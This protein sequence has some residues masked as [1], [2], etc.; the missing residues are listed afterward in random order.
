M[1]GIG[2][3]DLSLHR[4]GD[5]AAPSGYP[6]LVSVGL[7]FRGP[8]AVWGSAAGRDAT[9]ARTTT[10][11]GASFP[12]TRLD[13][14]IEVA[15]TAY[16]NG[17]EPTTVTVVADLPLALPHIDR[18]PDGRWLV[19]GSRCRW[20]PEGPENNALLY[21]ADGRLLREGCLGDGLSHVRV[22]P[23]NTIWTGYFDE[24][25]YGNFG[26]G[27][28]SGPQ[29]LGAGGIVTWDEDFRKVWELNEDEFLVDDCYTLNV[30]DGVAWACPYANFPVVRMAAGS[31]EVFATE[32]ITGPYAV[33]AQG[34]R[35][36]MLGTYG[37]PTLVV[38]GRLGEGLLHEEGRRRLRA[39]DLP[40]ERRFHVYASGPVVHFFVGSTWSTLSLDDLDL[41]SD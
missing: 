7:S 10:P 20:R 41:A 14:P 21:A 1:S 32:G 11:G 28:P 22:A 35:V 25:V 6:S 18:F 33:I 30:A 4:Y 24:G 38:Y 34:E 27:G 9:L 16:E 13:R 39:K 31:T 17:L 26:W 3:G 36:A 19:V 2:D 23:D 12:G 29:P 5:L 40:V 15:L 37:D 8:V